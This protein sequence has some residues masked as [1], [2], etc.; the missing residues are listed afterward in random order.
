[1]KNT[2]SFFRLIQSFTGNGSK[3]VIDEYQRK[4]VWDKDRAINLIKTIIS[5]KT[6]VFIGTFIIYSPDSSEVQIVDGQQRLVTIYIIMKC[7]KDIMS[8]NPELYNEIFSRKGHV[9]VQHLERAYDDLIDDKYSGEHKLSFRK[10]EV[11]EDFDIV[12]RNSKPS[13]Y[14]NSQIFKN[15]TAIKNFFLECRPEDLCDAYLNLLNTV[16]CFSME[17][18]NQIEAYRTFASINGLGQ[19]VEDKYS[20]IN[21]IYQ[22]LGRANKEICDLIENADKSFISRYLYNKTGKWVSTKEIIGQFTKYIENKNPE[23]IVNEILEFGELDRK[24]LEY[25]DKNY[26]IPIP[27]MMIVINHFMTSGLSDL[28]ILRL[29]KCFSAI[30]MRMQ[31][32]PAADHVRESNTAAI[33]PRIKTLKDIE[34]NINFEIAKGRLYYP[35][36]DVFRNSFK[37][38]DVYHTNIKNYILQTLNHQMSNTE[39]F[40]VNDVSVEHVM[41]QRGNAD[42]PL[43]HTIGNLTLTDTYK[44]SSMGTRDFAIKKEI[45]HNSIYS[46]N[47][48][49]DDVDKWDDDEILK[50]TELLTE[51]AVTAWNLYQY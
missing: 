21:I 4:Y 25:R 46:L 26:L 20:V 12:I 47:R 19:K 2:T 31:I 49:F 15:Y 10:K 28:E 17:C 29:T 34:D 24:C 7:L 50:R 27:A 45:L 48:Y 39:Q 42:N 44:N 11:E 37:R 38:Y 3:L 8:E 33:L 14:K 36:D 22:N 40:V 41:P 32:C 6:N 16:E 13:K 1:M 18:E 23:A 9:T 43:L 30:F 5:A 35:D 51:V